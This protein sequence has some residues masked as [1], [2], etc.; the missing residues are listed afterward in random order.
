MGKDSGSAQVVCPFYRVAGGMFVD[1]EGPFDGA[2]IRL[3]FG[4]KV[5]KRK[6]LKIF[7]CDQYKRCEIY[8]C[9]ME[10]KYPGMED[11]G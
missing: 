10:N 5:D 11:S 9:I 7:C 4:L 1:C 3:Q 2:N 6:Q 8:R